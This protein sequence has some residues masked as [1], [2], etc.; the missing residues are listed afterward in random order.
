[1][2]ETV[3]VTLGGVYQS[4]TIGSG[5]GFSTTFD[6]AALNV[7]N[8]PYTI[9]YVYAGDATFASA[10]TTSMLKVNPAPL[11]TFTVTS[12]GDAGIGSGDAGDLRY[13]LNQANADGGANRIVFSSTVFG[14]PQT[15]TLS[16]SQLELEDTVGTQTIT[17]PAAGVTISG[18]GNSRVFQVDSGV[19]ASISGLTISGG[20]IAYGS[21]AGRRTTE[22]RRSPTAP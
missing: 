15:I 7:V 13:C 12:L 22:W 19:T 16:G 17:G 18:G 3:A 5:G 1:M 9:T 8:S 21:G 10:G 11:T 20:L 14:T 4:A 6:T 2:G